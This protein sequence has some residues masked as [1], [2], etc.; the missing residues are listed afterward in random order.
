M[1][2]I[3]IIIKAGKT[4]VI[5]TL[6]NGLKL[7]I[8]VLTNEDTV[9]RLVVRRTRKFSSGLELLGVQAEG[10]RRTGCVGC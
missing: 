2:G 7:V 1:K 6:N 4:K 5:I 10:S 8:T 9:K 3:L